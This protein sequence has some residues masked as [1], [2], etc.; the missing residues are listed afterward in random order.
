MSNR[1]KR[2][3]YQPG[4][5]MSPSVTSTPPTTSIFVPNPTIQETGSYNPNYYGNQSSRLDYT[6]NKDNTYTD[7]TQER[8]PYSGLPLSFV[9][10]TESKKPFFEGGQGTLDIGNIEEGQY[11]NFDVDLYKG[12]NFDR[13]RAINQK[14]EY[15]TAFKNIIPG[16]IAGIVENVGYLGALATEWGTDRDYKNWFTETGKAMKKAWTNPIYQQDPNAQL[17]M[18][19]NDEGHWFNDEWW[20]SNVVDGLTT[21]ILQF[22]LTGMGVGAAAGKL[23]NI[24]ANAAKL[25][26]VGSNALNKTAQVATAFTLSYTEGAMSGAR[27]YEDVMKHHLD[28][29]MSFEDAKLR[30]SKAAA[31]TAQLSTA[32]NTFLN[33]GSVSPFFKANT[34]LKDELGKDTA[35]KM[36]GITDDDIIK[37]GGKIDPKSGKAMGGDITKALE[38][39]K[40]RLEA[41]KGKEGM[42]PAVMNTVKESGKEG[43]EEINTLYAEKE[44]ERYGKNYSTY[45]EDAKNIFQ[46]LNNFDNI[47][48]YGNDVATKEGLQNFILG[49]MGG[50]GQTV[51]TQNIPYKKVQSLD[52]EGNRV[53]EADNITPVY[54]RMSSNKEQSRNKEIAVNKAKMAIIKDIDY[55]NGK[56]KELKDVLNDDK[57]DKDTQ[58]QKADEIKNDLFTFNIWL[59]KNKDAANATEGY[60]TMMSGNITAMRNTFELMQNADN[61]NSIVPELMKEKEALQKEIDET[62]ARGEDTSNLVKEMTKLDKTILDNPTQAMYMGFAQDRNDNTYKEKAKEAINQLDSYSKRYD[63]IMN[64]K[65]YGDYET[66]EYA[67]DTFKVSTGIDL[68]NDKLIPN[69]QKDVDNQLDIS[70]KYYLANSSDKAGIAWDYAKNKFDNDTNKK[71]IEELRKDNTPSDIDS[72]S[73]TN[74]INDL[75]SKYPLDLKKL[76]AEGKTAEQI[77]KALIAK[78]RETR[79]KEADKLQK[80]VNLAD[81]KEADAKATLDSIFTP[82]ELRDNL[83]KASDSIAY[84]PFLIESKAKLNRNKSNL[85]TLQETYREL[86]D[87]KGYNEFVKAGREY[88]LKVQKEIEKIS[89]AAES[90]S[91][92]DED[93][94]KKEPSTTTPLTEEPI[95][96]EELTDEQLRTKLD[97]WKQSMLDNQKT[98]YTLKDLYNKLQS[99]FSN[100]IDNLDK[101]LTTFEATPN[102][103][104]VFIT[105]KSSDKVNIPMYYAPKSN[106]IYVNVLDN[107]KNVPIEKFAEMLLHEVVHAIITNDLENN[108]VLQEDIANVISNLLPD[109][110]LDTYQVL[111]RYTDKIA[112]EFERLNNE[113]NDL[114]NIRNEMLANGEN[115]TNIDKALSDNANAINEIDLLLDVF[116][117]IINKKDSVDMLNEFVTRAI[118]NPILGNHLNTIKA[119]AEYQNSKTS[120]KSIFDVLIDILLGAYL[121]L[122]N[123]E[124]DA[125]TDSLLYYLKGILSNHIT[126]TP[127]NSTIPGSIKINELYSRPID[128]VPTNI[129][130]TSIKNGEVTY[131]YKTPNGA[132]KSGVENELMFEDNLRNNTYQHLEPLVIAK[133]EDNLVKSKI[134]AATNILQQLIDDVYFISNT[135]RNKYI[136]LYT[137]LIDKL[138]NDKAKADIASILKHIQDNELEKAQTVL[139][140][141]EGIIDE[142]RKTLAEKIANAILAQSDVDIKTLNFDTLEVD[143]TLD[144]KKKLEILRKY[145]AELMK[146]YDVKISTLSNA[147]DATKLEKEIEKRYKDAAPSSNTKKKEKGWSTRY[148]LFLAAKTDLLNKIKIF[149]GLK[150]VQVIDN[151]NTLYRIKDTEGDIVELLELD[152][153]LNDTKKKTIKVSKGAIYNYTNP[154]IK[155]DEHQ[156]NIYDK[157]Y[158]G[159]LYVPNLNTEYYEQSDIEGFL[160]Y[161]QVV[162]TSESALKDFFNSINDTFRKKFDAT[163]KTKDFEKLDAKGISDLAKKIYEELNIGDKKGLNK[164]NYRSMKKQQHVDFFKTILAKH[165]GNYE[166]AKEEFNKRTHIIVRAAPD[167]NKTMSNNTSTLSD[168]L[169]QGVISANPSKIA[170]N[171][172]FIGFERW[173]DIEISLE[174]QD[175]NGKWVDMGH[176]NNPNAFVKVD[177]ANEDS[178]PYHPGTILRENISNTD[179]VK[180]FNELY[181]NREGTP[182]EFSDLEAIGNQFNIIADLYEKYSNEFKANGNNNITI[183]TS[184]VLKIDVMEGSLNYNREFNKNYTPVKEIKDVQALLDSKDHYIVMTAPTDTIFPNTTVDGKT[185]P[186]YADYGDKLAKPSYQSKFWLLAKDIQG[187][188]RPIAVRSKQVADKDI[189]DLLVKLK[190]LFD[191]SKLSK[192]NI[193]VTRDMQLQLNNAFDDVVYFADNRANMENIKK[194][195]FELVIN[196]DG[197]TPKNSKIQLK[198]DRDGVKSY[199]DL[200]ITNIDTFNKSLTD[201]GF[202]LNN[203]RVS[204]PDKVDD[205]ETSL[206]PNNLFNKNIIRFDFTK[207]AKSVDEV[208]E[209][210]VEEIIKEDEKLSNDIVEQEDSSEVLNKYDELN[211]LIESNLDALMEHLDTEGIIAHESEESELL[212]KSTNRMEFIE[213]RINEVSEGD[214]SWAEEAL[215]NV[216]AKI[217]E[218]RPPTDKNYSSTISNTTLI[219]MY[220]KLKGCK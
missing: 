17:N 194:S 32:M 102:T 99:E 112:T 86:M 161:A 216:I 54:E 48:E 195:S 62:T 11:N 59:N 158:I 107:H 49:A 108:V 136:S 166:L 123:T 215:N 142:V 162:F 187:N 16:T 145:L 197:F 10:N 191:T 68:Y 27:V 190:N 193:T 6:K 55:Q 115:I 51:L 66:Y 118:T 101:Y 44:G 214:T 164:S 12:N 38:N 116:Q 177:L 137:A 153:K 60:D 160:T 211:S 77:D 202:S 185:I 182:M 14:D 97:D 31:K 154:D 95:V 89:K 144:S 117:N 119:S 50:V 138:N 156:E 199:M 80:D 42:L 81:K 7:N 2:K 30:A 39:S 134:G 35:A 69:I 104:V 41:I 133:L 56:L 72:L 19:G 76:E 93:K 21:S 120:V 22:G 150:V 87:T 125:N 63:E 181:R 131:E 204:K 106:T 85:K 15:W 52:A 209:E 192:K 67:R 218:L 152:D 109:K 47:L 169:A 73:Y 210:Q 37:A 189:K 208:I 171:K 33:L 88:R 25:G 26:A 94:T 178:R 4:G 3:K 43:V 168:K 146:E 114:G 78:D 200:D 74:Y 92:D 155:S 36:V 64:N 207:D 186:N 1:I 84:N 170:S 173:T 40:I 165:N 91:G 217:N 20:A 212:N 111:T 180:I 29:G 75:K 149:K 203:L 34:R 151:L 157:A 220:N 23:A 83:D 8:D 213:N 159:E 96:P 163:I 139:T 167:V 61:S 127:L 184:E 5:S 105:N 24:T 198:I 70:K 13:Q 82:E 124:I 176:I 46:K 206:N 121:K 135:N 201:K 18:F 128:S 53:F 79:N 130:I 9:R 147:E 71:H 45:E 174:Y 110:G 219:D 90:D 143:S 183:D 58:K 129:R 100:H 98:S 113:A 122:T 205:F 188:L 65:N 140:K 172:E 175:D 57:L 132:T 103:K 148:K 196:L 179:K 141:S 28:S 126:I